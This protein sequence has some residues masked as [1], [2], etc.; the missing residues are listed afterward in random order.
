[1]TTTTTTDDGF[2][3][4]LCGGEDCD[5]TNPEVHPDAQELPYD[6]VDNDCDGEDLTDADDDGFFALS[7]DGGTDCD[8]TDPQVHPGLVEICDDGI[9][10]DCDEFLDGD[11]EVCGACAGCE[12]NLAGKG[13]D[14]RPF[15]LFLI[16]VSSLRR[17]IR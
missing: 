16:L 9:D 17:R 8:D 7:V 3:D 1:M 2:V 5:D 15:L 14:P 13:T 10:N 6:G 4:D 11:D 12:T